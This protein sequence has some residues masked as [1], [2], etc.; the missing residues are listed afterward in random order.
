VHASTHFRIH[1]FFPV[2]PGQEETTTY[3]IKKP[4]KECRAYLCLGSTM[5]MLAGA[6]AL[7]GDRHF[8][9]YLLYSHW[10]NLLSC[11]LALD[12]GIFNTFFRIA[13]QDVGPY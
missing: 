3:S 2:T 8:F 13:Q 4:G 7:A 5:L 10:K 12:S 6:F 1:S 9:C 11:E